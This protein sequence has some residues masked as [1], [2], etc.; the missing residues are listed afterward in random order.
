MTRRLPELALFSGKQVLITGGLGFLG[1][2]LAI[3]LVAAGARVT[4][5]DAMLEGHGG[6]LFNIEPVRDDVMVNFS[7]MR[8][9]SGLKSL[10]SGKDYIF[11]LAG[12]H[13]HVLSLSNPFPDVEINVKGALFLLEAC[14]HW[15]NPSARLV[16]SGTRGEYGPTATM[17]VGEDWPTNPRGIYE[18][19]SLT[20]QRLFKIYNDT[21]GIRS[22]TL[23]LTNVY[24]ERA[25][26]RHDHFGVANWFV[27]LAIDGATIQ[28]F[29]DGSYKRDFIYQGDAVDAILMCAAAEEAFGE[30][31][32]IGNDRVSNFREL[33]ETIVRV[34]GS[35]RWEYTAFSTERAALEPG[36]FCSDISK[37]NR[38][39][40]WRPETGLEEGI[41]KTIDYYRQHKEQYWG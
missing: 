25:Q 39:V 2:N 37:I 31:L 10:V 41:A 21:H 35:G 7:D 4:L 22:V 18:L 17:P 3:R 27:R 24:G 32:N 9:S 23:R 16:Y 15:H 33:A 34:S 11:H 36:D 30:T 1:S 28:V 6:N 13:D 8:D 38:L 26:M 20:T 14:R 19:S 29:G 40:G 12:H 5:L